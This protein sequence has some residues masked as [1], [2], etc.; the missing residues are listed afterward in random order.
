MRLR[1]LTLH[2]LDIPFRVA[3]RHASAE[4]ERTETVWVE[5]HSEHAIGFGE[6]CPRAYVTGETLETAGAFFTRHFDALRTGIRRLDDLLAF[7]TEYEEEIDANPAAWCAIELALLDALAKEEACSVEA[8]C[9]LPE[10]RGPFHYSAVIG[11]TGASAFGRFLEA[12]AGLGMRDFKV[13][14]SGDVGM[15]RENL[16]VLGRRVP[17][18]RLRLDANNLWPD[19]DSAARYLRGLQ[20]SLFAVEEPLQ[21]RAYG[22]LAALSRTLGTRIVLDESCVRAAQLEDLEGLGDAWALNVRVS[23][24]GGLR[25]SLASVEAARRRGIP[26]VVGAQVGETSVLTRAALAVATFAGGSV[27]AQEGGFGTLLL[28]EDVCAAPLQFGPRGDLM[29]E[30]SG[31]PGFGLSICVADRALS[32][33]PPL[34]DLRSLP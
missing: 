34:P 5:A 20:Q 13:K 2:R 4:R 10:P 8:L 3:F 25:R 33:L 21:P 18:R 9:G 24:M 11:A 23:K 32:T 27:V 26:I 6:G 31:R 16:K 30:N 15:D 14:V 12:Y 29:W 17:G 28:Q 19:V 22:E 7:G 1:T